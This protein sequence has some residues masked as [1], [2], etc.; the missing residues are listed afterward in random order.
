MP[1]LLRAFFCLFDRLLQLGKT[2]FRINT[3][4]RNVSRL[5]RN[6]VVLLA[7]SLLLLVGEFVLLYPTR[8]ERLS[9]ASAWL[10]M[11]LLVAVLVIGPLQRRDGRPP[12]LNIYLRRDLGCWAALLGWLHFVAGNVVAMNAL[13]VGTFVRGVAAPPG[14][15]IREI[16]FSGGAIL[17]LIVAVL[18]LL[19]LAIS[20]DRAIRL[21]G[22]ARWKKLQWS[23]H[24]VLW[25]TILHGI[26]YQVLEARYLPM[27]GLL[28]ASAVVLRYRLMAP[29]KD[30][31][32]AA[33]L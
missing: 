15:A 28:A 32:S 17:G 3:P 30:R 8:W 13:Y 11:A 10:C 6:L 21:L 29:S 18:F 22:L 23:A 27:L 14:P 20:S 25:L 5:K 33:G 24:L 26:A 4:E 31:A 19:L 7:G 16:L 2:P 1:A 12:A 9:V